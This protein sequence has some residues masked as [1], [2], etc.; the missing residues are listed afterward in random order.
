MAR[1]QG[2]RPPIQSESV[3]PPLR[4]PPSHVESVIP[5]LHHPPS[6]V[7][8]P[9]RVLQRQRK[10]K[11]TKKGRRVLDPQPSTRKWSIFCFIVH[12]SNQLLTLL[13]DN[14]N[15]IHRERKK[16][17]ADKGKGKGKAPAVP[18]GMSICLS[19]SSMLAHS[20]VGRALMK[21]L[22]CLL[23]HVTP[24]DIHQ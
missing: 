10:K 13:R 14:S 17:K 9:H 2:G 6:H 3:T 20:I 1:A 19:T 15:N 4:R 12:A 5:P 8:S 7:G 11:R 21:G 24:S 16:A 23:F 18:D 22:F